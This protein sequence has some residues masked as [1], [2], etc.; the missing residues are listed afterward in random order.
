[1]NTKLNNKPMAQ[2]KNK[3]S[4]Y[5]LVTIAYVLATMFVLQEE[6]TTSKDRF[7]IIWLWLASMFVTYIFIKS[8]ETYKK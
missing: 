6:T 4:I 7:L 8:N 2:Q 5:I 3:Y 1:M